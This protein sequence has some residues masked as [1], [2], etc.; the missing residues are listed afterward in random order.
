MDM[1]EE[2]LDRYGDAH[3]VNNLLNIALSNQCNKVY[4]RNGPQG[5]EVNLTMYPKAKIDVGRIPDLLKKYPKS[6]HFYAQPNPHFIYNLPKPS[7]GKTDTIS[8]FE[9]IKKLLD[10]AMLLLPQ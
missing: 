7:R 8:I 5:Y 10:D 2:L 3:A 4:I 6:L 9:S 1:Q